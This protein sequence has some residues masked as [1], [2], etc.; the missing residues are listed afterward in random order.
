MEVGD[1]LAGHRPLQ[2]ALQLLLLHVAFL[3]ASLLV[4]VRILRAAL[5]VA[6]RSRGGAGQFIS[7]LVSGNQ[8]RREDPRREDALNVH[9][10]LLANV[11]VE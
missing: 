9:A 10:Q 2:H 6:Q 11:E 5:G 4:H 7:A 8:A 1:G 3:F